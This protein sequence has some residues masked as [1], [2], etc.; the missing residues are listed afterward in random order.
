[1]GRV[2]LLLLRR[3]LLVVRLLLRRLL[4]L[5]R[6]TL[7]LLLARRLVELRSGVSDAW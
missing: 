1:M 5:V 6:R 4:L 3:L 7:R 2:S